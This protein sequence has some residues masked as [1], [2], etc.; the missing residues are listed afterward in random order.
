MRNAIIIGA[1]QGSGKA[2]ALL[3]AKKGYSVILT[4]R[5]PE[6]LEAVAQQINNSGGIMKFAN[7]KN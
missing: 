4:A 6:R 1:S 3:F 7:T 5:T 2:T